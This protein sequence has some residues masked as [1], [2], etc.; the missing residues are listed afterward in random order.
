MN[1]YVLNNQQFTL[2]LEEEWSSYREVTVAYLKKVSTKRG[3]Y[4]VFIDSVG[5][6]YYLR[7]RHSGDS[8]E[9]VM[10]GKVL[11]NVDKEARTEAGADLTLTI[12][13]VG[14]LRLLDQ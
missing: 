6:T 4:H 5:E 3:E 2:G 9:E 12:F 7:P 13:A 14:S 11:V 10:V 1:E 8:I